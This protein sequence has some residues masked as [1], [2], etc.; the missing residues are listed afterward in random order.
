M[1]LETFADDSIRGGFGYSY[2]H[3]GGPEKAQS[4]DMEIGVGNIVVEVIDLVTDDE[5]AD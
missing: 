3:P 4:L 5:H 1:E 2:L